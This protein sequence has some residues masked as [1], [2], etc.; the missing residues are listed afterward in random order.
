MK[1]IILLIMLFSSSVFGLTTPETI[2]KNLHIYSAGGSTFVDAVPHEC[3]GSRYIIK[4]DHIR[5]KEIFS[6]LMAAQISK[7]KVQLRF[8]ECTDRGRGEVIG[9]YLK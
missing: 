3:S 4:N 1:K 9:V 2:P 5:Y 8:E 6:M 7:T